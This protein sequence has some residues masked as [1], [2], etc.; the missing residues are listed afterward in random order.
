MFDAA[1][2]GEVFYMGHLLG[3]NFLFAEMLV[4]CVRAATHSQLHGKKYITIDISN[5]FATGKQA[6]WLHEQSTKQ[7]ELNFIEPED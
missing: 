3:P 4:L 7:C 6:T 5:A 1:V 2:Y